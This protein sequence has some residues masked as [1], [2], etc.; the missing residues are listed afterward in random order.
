MTVFKPVEGGVVHRFGPDVVI[1]EDSRISDLRDAGWPRH[2]KKLK[3]ATPSIT[4][5]A[6]FNPRKGAA[7]RVAARRCVTG[8][9]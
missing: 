4:S 7:S 6:S 3:P 9:A 2:L 8:M 1:K 5:S